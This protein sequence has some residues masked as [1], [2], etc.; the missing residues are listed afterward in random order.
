MLATICL[1]NLPQQQSRPSFQYAKDVELL[2]SMMNT[3]TD[4]H[5]NNQSTF[6][7]ASPN[8]PTLVE[9]SN[10]ETLMMR[11]VPTDFDYHYHHQHHGQEEDIQHSQQTNGQ[12]RNYSRAST[13]LPP[14]SSQLESS[15][16]M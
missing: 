9:N 11:M 15:G 7:R 12:T 2:W 8:H 3:D 14:Q 16:W 5:L 4:T 6:S 10:N 13:Q 1:Q